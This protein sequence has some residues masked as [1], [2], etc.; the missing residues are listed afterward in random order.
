MS[1][2]KFSHLMEAIGMLGRMALVVIVIGTFVGAAILIAG[3]GALP[4]P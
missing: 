1:A 2:P 4:P 3:P